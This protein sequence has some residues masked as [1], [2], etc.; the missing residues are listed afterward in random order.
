MEMIHVCFLVESEL[1][2]VYMF[3][4]V[5]LLVYRPFMYM[6]VQGHSENESLTVLIILRAEPESRLLRKR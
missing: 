1:I 3:I 2:Y 5:S 4:Y 6:Y